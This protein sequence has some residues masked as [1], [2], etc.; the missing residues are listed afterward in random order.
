MIADSLGQE[1]HDRSTRG[2]LLSAEE[3]V[4]LERWYEDQ[5]DLERKILSP[6]AA[7]KTTDKLQSKIEVTLTQLIT[8]T[9]RIREVASENESLRQE[10]NGLRHQLAD[11]S[12]IQRTL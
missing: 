11:S 12:P 1:L 4:Q 3:Q 8:T 6:S 10:I 2:E 9:N 5:D 7:E